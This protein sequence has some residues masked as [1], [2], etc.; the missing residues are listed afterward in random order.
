MLWGKVPAWLLNPV[1]GPLRGNVK[2]SEQLIR[3]LSDLL[4]SS[5]DY[6]HTLVQIPT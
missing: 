4:I 2:R 1:V 3:G 5:Y 6:S